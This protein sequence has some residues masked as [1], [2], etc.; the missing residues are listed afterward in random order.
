VCRSSKLEGSQQSEAGAKSHSASSGVKTSATKDSGIH[1]D[2]DDD[3][4][5]DDDNVDDLQQQ[6]KKKK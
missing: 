3:D 2:D 1:D 6:Q 5:D 4:N